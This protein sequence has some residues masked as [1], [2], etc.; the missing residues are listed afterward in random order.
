MFYLDSGVH[1]HEIKFSGLIQKKFYGSCTFIACCLC[2][3]YCCLTHFLSQIIRD[4]DTWRLFDHFL[5]TSLN[6]ASLVLPD[7]LHFRI[8]PQ[9]SALQHVWDSPQTVPDTWYYRRRN[10]RLLLCCLKQFGKF[11]F[12]SGYTH[13]F[14]TAAC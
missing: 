8:Y 9:E 12:I 2:C 1:F 4:C 10:G 6:R 7:E 11:L 14:S 3:P 13:S 5:V